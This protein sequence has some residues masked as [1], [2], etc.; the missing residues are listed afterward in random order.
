M[1]DRL[2]G[3][4]RYFR[5]TVAAQANMGIDFKVDNF[6]I[7]DHKELVQGK[8]NPAAC[9]GIFAEAKKNTFDDENEAKQKPFV[10]I[11]I[12][13]KTIKT[14]FDANEK[15]QDEIDELTGI[16]YVP[17]ILNEEGLL[18]FDEG[19]KK[20]PWFPREYLM[21][22]VEPKL[23]VG[24]ADAVDSFM[25]NHVD[26]IEKIKSWSDYS[27]FFKGLYEAVADSPFEQNIIRNMDAK[28]PFFE[29]ENNMYIFLDKTV[30]STFHIMNLYNHL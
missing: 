25:S 3:I 22:M 12:C 20:L 30:Y 24:T 15:V 2:K 29:L 14:I 27:V 6:F 10:N 1:N 8:I 5:S 28:E 16:Y 11:I 4:T 23:A 21:P 26:R 7:V 9:E 19:E 17:A 13:A 18:L